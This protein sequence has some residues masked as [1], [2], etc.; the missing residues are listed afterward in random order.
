M[1]LC[2]SYKNKEEHIKKVIF[3]KVVFILLSFLNELF[4]YF[5]V[6]IVFVDDIR[7]LCSKPGTSLTAR[8]DLRMT[9]LVS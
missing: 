8:R 6:Y 2:Y 3:F 4:P 9:D 5:L 7:K 1:C